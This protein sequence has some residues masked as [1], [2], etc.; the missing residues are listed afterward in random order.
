MPA[1]PKIEFCLPTSGKAVPSGPDWIH[2]IKY[3]GYRLRVER[4]RDRVK[5]TSRGGLDWTRRFPWIAETAR[6]IRKTQFIIDGEAVVLGVDGISDFNALHSRKHDHEVQLY[7]FD[8]LAYDG[9]DLSRLP[10]HLR[11]T[12]LAQLLRGRAEGIFVAP[13]EQGEIGPELFEA[14][15]RMGLEGLVSKH[16]ERVYW[17]GRCDHWVKVK[18]R[19]HPAFS[20]VADQF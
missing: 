17:P 10:L 6:K 20:R 15:C 2:E 7:A 5:L 16:R 9:D 4:Y 18:N 1:M 19:K 8:C 12:N 14:A 3:D 13:F 11:K